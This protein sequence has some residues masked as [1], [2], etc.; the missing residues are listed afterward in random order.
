MYRFQYILI[1]KTNYM[2]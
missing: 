1:V 2:E